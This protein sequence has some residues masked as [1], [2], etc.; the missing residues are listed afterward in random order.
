MHHTRPGPQAA[1][2]RRSTGQWQPLPRRSTAGLVGKPRGWKGCEEE[3][4]EEEEEE[5]EKEEKEEEFCKGGHWI[6]EC[7]IQPSLKTAIRM[8]QGNWS[9][10]KA[11]AL[12]SWWLL[13]MRSNEE[14]S[15]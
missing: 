9:S 5:E 11:N 14:Y 2:G 12:S 10:G 8:K 4:E 6:K 1:T 13:T 15:P 3:K 7:I